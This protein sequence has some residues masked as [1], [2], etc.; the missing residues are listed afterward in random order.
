MLAFSAPFSGL[1][2]PAFRWDFGAEETTKLEEH[3]GVHRDVPGPRPP[4]FPEFDAN[5]T[6]V[7]LDGNGAHFTFP[8]PGPSK[9]GRAHV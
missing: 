4:E 7:L 9:I 5:N 1:A 8:D 6:A 2:A 3:G